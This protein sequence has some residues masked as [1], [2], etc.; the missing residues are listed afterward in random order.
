[1]SAASAHRPAACQLYLVADAGLAAAGLA[2]ALDGGPVACVLLRA[3]TEVSDDGALRAAIEALRPVAQERGVAFLIEDR[4]ELAAETGCDGVHLSRDGPRVR[5]ARQGVGADAIVGAACDSSRHAAMSAAE[6][7]A[8]YVAF[9]DGAAD[10]RGG[11]PADPELLAWWSG[12]MTVPCVAVTG[13][14]PQAAA[15]LAAAGAD[16]VAVGS[17][18]WAHPDGP[19]AA[20]GELL[21]AIASREP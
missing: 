3:A 13:G 18:V 12:I 5:D 7:G 20:V 14:D 11:E 9:G 4:P 19:G 8:D 15:A 2:A 10:G 1:M 17:G 6:A 16:F 21:A